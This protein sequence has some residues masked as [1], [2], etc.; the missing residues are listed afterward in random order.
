MNI[1][2]QVFEEKINKGETFS[3][4]EIGKEAIQRGGNCR[5][6][7]G[8]TFKDYVKV[9]EEMGVIKFNFYDNNYIIFNGRL[10]ILLENNYNSSFGKN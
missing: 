1:A 9:L 7:P 10:E 6:A 2:K 4:E 8:V 3:L 5:V